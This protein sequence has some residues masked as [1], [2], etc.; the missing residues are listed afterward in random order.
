[1]ISIPNEVDEPVVAMPLR[2]QAWITVTTRVATSG[3]FPS[4]TRTYLTKPTTITNTTI[5]LNIIITLIT[6]IIFITLLTMPNG[7]IPRTIL[8]GRW[9]HSRFLMTRTWDAPGLEMDLIVEIMKRICLILLSLTRTTITC[10][11]P[12][13]WLKV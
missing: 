6:T 12:K 2:Q 11:G 9:P 5:T 10:I 7:V 3:P 8:R 13:T 1:M 4:R